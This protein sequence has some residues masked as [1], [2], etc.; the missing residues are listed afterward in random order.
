MRFPLHPPLTV[1]HSAAVK[2]LFNNAERRI[3]LMFLRDRSGFEVDLLSPTPSGLAAISIKS[4]L[5]MALD[6]FSPLRRLTEFLPQ[7]THYAVLY[8]GDETQQRNGSYAA[9]LTG[10]AGLL[11]CY[12]AQFLIG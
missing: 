12:D 10:I 8:S 6:W 3:D 9:L 7:I 11:A 2:H 5:I 4:G 1:K